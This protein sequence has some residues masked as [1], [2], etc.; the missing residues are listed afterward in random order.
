MSNRIG[1]LIVVTFALAI[2]LYRLAPVAFP[3]RYGH[4]SVLQYTLVVP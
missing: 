3:D 2:L 1:V 4:A